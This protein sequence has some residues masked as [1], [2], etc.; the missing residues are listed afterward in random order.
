ME[1]FLLRCVAQ[2]WEDLFRARR[3]PAARERRALVWLA[4]GAPLGCVGRSARSLHGPW[5][6]GLMLQ[7]AKRA[8]SMRTEAMDRGGS[9]RSGLRNQG[10]R[11][12]RARQAPYATERSAQRKRS[13]SEM[14]K[15]SVA[16]R[17]SL[18]HLTRVQ[19]CAA[20]RRSL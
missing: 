11:L 4:S 16:G 12:K 9:E 13:E 5:L 19:R 18:L 14:N 15:M 8:S 2:A 7:R 1:R 10:E 17:C 3:G 20:L 6:E